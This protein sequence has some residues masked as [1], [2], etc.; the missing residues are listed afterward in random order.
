MAD[1]GANGSA[2]RLESIARSVLL[3]AVSRIMVP[4][5]M[6]AVLGISGWAGLAL[7]D[8]S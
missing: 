2:A 6:T 4:A 8:L 5:G 7:W 1:P 3:T